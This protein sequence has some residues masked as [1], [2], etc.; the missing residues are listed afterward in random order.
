ME[1]FK[2]FT[3]YANLLNKAKDK[4]LTFTGGDME[5][6]M[7]ILKNIDKVHIFEMDD[8]VK[9]LLLITKAPKDNK[10]LRLP[11]DN[12]FLEISMDIKEMGFN[13]NP[14]LKEIKGILISQ[15]DKVRDDYDFN[16]ISIY[17]LIKE[18]DTF[19]FYKGVLSAETDGVSISLEDDDEIDALVSNDLGKTLRSFSINFLNFINNPEIEIESNFRS[20]R[21]M[22]LK[23]K[24]GNPVYSSTSKIIL[25]GNLKEQLEKMDGLGYEF[26]HKFWVRGHFHKYHTNNGAVVKWILPYIKGKG[27]LVENSYK[28]KKGVT[29][30]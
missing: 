12:T 25:K 22:E 15:V 17:C 5:E 13:K 20:E 11:F 28:L 1:N 19:S 29:I 21:N 27:T 4:D 9:N 16:E 18:D 14:K 30:K 24:R 8:T 23:R 10:G 2:H 6:E 7:S 26:N 3:W